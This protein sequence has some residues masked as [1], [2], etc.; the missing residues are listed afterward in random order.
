M[1]D[2]A[3]TVPAPAPVRPTGLVPY[4]AA[5]NRPRLLAPGPVETDPRTMLALA[6]PQIHHRTPE[7]RAVVQEARARL[8]RLLGAPSWEV[9]ITTSSGT[10]AF[11]AALTSLVP[12][13]AGVVAASAGKFGERWGDM[14]QTLGYKVLRVTKAWGDTLDPHEVA[15]AC[16]NQRA[17]LVTH[18]ET[19]TGALHDL[20]AIA[21]AAKAANP[22]LLIVVDA[23]T[24]YAVA[25][26]RPEA[27]GLDVV[28]SGSQ[29]GVAGP[30]GL[31]FVFL[32]PR[33]VE[34]LA[35]GRRAY[36]FDLC[37]E[38]S[39]QRKGESAQTPAIN[40]IA[41][42]N[43]STE[44][45]LKVPLET[46]W[47]EKAR[48]NAALLAAGLALGC[49]PFAA[50]PSPAV[51][52]LVPPEGVNGKQVANALSSLGARAAAGQ[53]P[54]A[55]DIFRVSLMGYFDRYDALAAAGLLEDA[56]SGLGV[57]VTRGAAVNTAWRVLSER[58]SA[59]SD[60]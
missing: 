53:A 57:N 22:G 37:K 10:G 52:A 34:L 49:Q 4:P 5:L 14:A 47:A 36:S 32:S 56:L 48:V 6:A 9:L 18:S 7:A 58:A 60:L 55:D 11:E 38:L 24:S 50:R 42:L 3:P 43:A 51:A 12:E 33:A 41:S 25:E 21:R 27:W 13:G 44:R 40:L 16:V 31:G 23:V 8:L 30:P 35:P 20:G 28:V 45:L 19:S 17:L 54:M 39:A 2:H 1:S 15:F 46:L 26:L 59:S 29:K